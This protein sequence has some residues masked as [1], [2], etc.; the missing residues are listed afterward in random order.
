LPTFGTSNDLIMP[1]NRETVLAALHAPL[2][3]LA[4]LTMRDE[5]LPEQIPAPGLII[6]R[7]AQPGEPEVTCHRCATTTS[8]APNR[9]SSFRRA[10]TSM[11]S[12]CCSHH[13]LAPIRFAPNA[14]K[15]LDRPTPLRDIALRTQSP[16]LV[17][18]NAGWG[19]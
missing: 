2:K 11:R 18:L 17:L 8:T 12:A 10:P 9:R 13:A 15:T 14:P 3:P 6:L 1:T 19:G 5:V 4:A 16:W 7:D